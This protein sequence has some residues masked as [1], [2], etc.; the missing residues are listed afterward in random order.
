MILFSVR[1]YDYSGHDLKHVF[2]R[3]SFGH[4]R[5]W[6]RTRTL[7][8]TEGDRGLPSKP[9]PRPPSTNGVGPDETHLPREGS[10]HSRS[11]TG[12]RNRS[13]TV[14][15]TGPGGT[16]KGHSGGRVFSREV[17]PALGSITCSTVDEGRPP[18]NV[19]PSRSITPPPGPS[20]DLQG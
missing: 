10:P 19:G 15:R 13:A 14:V 7:S 20:P 11:A 9:L 5:T 6:C 18:P 2:G 1:P 17:F 3:L 12:P 4:P 8:V 16:T